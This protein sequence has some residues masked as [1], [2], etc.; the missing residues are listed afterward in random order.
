MPSELHQELTQRALVWVR[1]M[2]TLRGCRRGFEIP[3]AQ[4]YVADAIALCSFQNRFSCEYL[5]EEERRTRFMEPEHICIFEAKQSRAD[6]L[7]TFGPGPN[8]V[9]RHEPIGTLHWCIAPRGLIKPDEVPGFW[10]LLEPAGRGLR[11]IKRPVFCHQEDAR[12][13][14]VAYMVL[15]YGEN[16]KGAWRLKTENSPFQ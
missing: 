9:N 6:F 11:E 4:G 14:E 3:V 7:K 1:K 10:G 5:L 8:H 16:R 2:A 12:L 15:W 13:F